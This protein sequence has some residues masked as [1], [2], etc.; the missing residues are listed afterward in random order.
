MGCI[1]SKS[2]KDGGEHLSDKSTE[3][4][5]KPNV[6]LNTVM[7]DSVPRGSLT[8]A[9]RDERSYADVKYLDKKKYVATEGRDKRLEE[10]KE[11]RRKEAEE[12]KRN[13]AWLFKLLGQ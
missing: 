6:K 9:E 11:N 5:K 1:K 10:L 2:A 3:E 13:A 7:I 12:D 4:E 8:N